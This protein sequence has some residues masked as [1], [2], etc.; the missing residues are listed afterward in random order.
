MSVMIPGFGILSKVVMWHQ[1]TE[2][3]LKDD[4]LPRCM[5]FL[6]VSYTSCSQGR[7]NIQVDLV[8]SSGA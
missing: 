3:T 4:R 6:K 8:P 5:E 2:S 1:C 7:I